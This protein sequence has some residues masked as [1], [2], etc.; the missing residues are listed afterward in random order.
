[1]VNSLF[2]ILVSYKVVRK[3]VMSTFDDF[4]GLFFLFGLEHIN[5][6]IPNANT[7]TNAGQ[8]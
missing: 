4:R 5:K 6:I 2:C 7:S 3:T 1:M 8:P